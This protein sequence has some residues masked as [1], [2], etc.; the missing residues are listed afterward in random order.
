[1]GVVRRLAIAAL[2]ASSLLAASC[3]NDNP[4]TTD[5]PTTDTPSAPTST[6]PTSTPTPA[7][8]KAKA[9]AAAKARY[10]TAMAARAA[11]VHNPA[12]ATEEDLVDGGAADP[13][14][15][16]IL[17]SIAF[18]RDNKLYETGAMR[19]TSMRETKVVLTG[20]QPEVRLDVCGDNTSVKLRY[21]SSGQVAPTAPGS[22]VKPRFRATVRYAPATGRPGKNWY[23]V[24]NDLVGSC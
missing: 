10:L 17:S 24:I 18:Y 6:P 1:M 20:E 16:S 7:D 4:A 3:S 13:W 11:A 12:K 21:A 9:A 5:P 14:I 8:P 2:L 15:G 19:V 23:V 22:K